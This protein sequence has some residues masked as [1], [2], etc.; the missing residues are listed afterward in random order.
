MLFF[1]K[2][3]ILT[4]FIS[5]AISQYSLAQSSTNLFSIDN[6]H[7]D[8]GILFE[9]FGLG[10]GAIHKVS[11]KILDS[12]HFEGFVGLAWQHNH[13]F[14]SIFETN[15]SPLI[16]SN[17][18]SQYITNDL[19]YYPFKKKHFFIGIGV[20]I[21]LTH[22]ITQGTL[23]IPAYNITESF[24]KEHTYL[25][26]GSMQTIGWSF[27]KK[28]QLSLYSMIS[29]KGLLDRGRAR[30]SEVDSRFHVGINLGFRFS[31]T[32]AK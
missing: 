23:E 26:Y 8:I 3:T 1:I 6:V 28:I 25:N 22:S 19:K 15:I 13:S 27:S 30:L 17:D 18:L 5:I 21:G 10:F 24:Y 7:Y 16:T 9:P 20:F 4:L 2:N 31:S 32:Q 14:K 29:L 11:I 12:D